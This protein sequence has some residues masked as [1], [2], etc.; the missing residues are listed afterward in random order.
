MPRKQMIAGLLICVLAGSGCQ[1]PSKLQHA[2]PV[3]EIPPLPPEIKK[4]EPNLLQRL[5]QLL[6]PSDTKATTPSAT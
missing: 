5:L 2:Q 6:Q 1:S 4:R 3:M